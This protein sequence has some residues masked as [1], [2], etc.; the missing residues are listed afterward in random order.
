MD[1]DRLSCVTVTLV[2]SHQLTLESLTTFEPIT[3]MF[4]RIISPE[5]NIAHA[6][7]M[8][9][10]VSDEFGRID[11]LVN[12]VGIQHVSPIHEFPEEKWDAIIA[13]CLTSAFHTT[14]AA[15]PHMLE[16]KWG[17]I[18]NTGARRYVGLLCRTDEVNN[19]QTTLPTW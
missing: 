12:N 10:R 8:M 7:E 15:L 18:I 4:Q 2:K 16:Q 13:V 9:K 14:K 6:R 1:Y 3:R 17:R 5:G 19:C 11:I